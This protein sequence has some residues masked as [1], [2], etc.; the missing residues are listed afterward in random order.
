MLSRIFGGK[1]PAASQLKI[2]FH[3]EANNLPEHG[4]IYADHHQFG[5]T[6][7]P[8]RFSF[9]E[10]DAAPNLTAA[11]LENIWDQAESQGYT[12]HSLRSYATVFP[13]MPAPRRSISTPIPQQRSQ[14]PRHRN[15]GQA[16]NRA[17]AKVDPIPQRPAQVEPQRVAPRRYPAGKQ[18]SS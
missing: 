18:S 6:N 10:L 8:I 4:T 7:E 2:K 11:V 12:P 5:L 15:D 14:Q 13:V 16:P 1:K 3:K 17:D 9:S